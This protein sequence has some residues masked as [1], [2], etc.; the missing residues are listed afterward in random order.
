LGTRELRRN[1]RVSPFKASGE[2]TGEVI[3]PHKGKRCGPNRAK[4]AL[5]QSEKCGSTEQ[6]SIGS[7]REIKK[8]ISV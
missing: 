5:L 4:G 7:N 2:G 1:G 3:T 8:T 6:T